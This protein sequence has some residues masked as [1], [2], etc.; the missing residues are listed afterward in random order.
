MHVCESNTPYPLGY[1]SSISV[2]VMKNERD[3]NEGFR[4]KMP[5]MKILPP[6]VIL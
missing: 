3:V 1:T 2:L 4:E 6:W 5:R